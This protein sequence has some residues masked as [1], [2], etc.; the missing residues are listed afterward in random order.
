MLP[1]IVLLQRKMLARKLGGSESR[2]F[3]CGRNAEV[4]CGQ[5]ILLNYLDFILTV[6]DYLVLLWF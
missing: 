2:L 3:T 1:A 6:L 5:C 4:G